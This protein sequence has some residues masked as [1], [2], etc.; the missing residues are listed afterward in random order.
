MYGCQWESNARYD[1]DDDDDPLR[2][3]IA[4]DDVEAAIW[5]DESFLPDADSF[6]EPATAFVAS[7]SEQTCGIACLAPPQAALSARMP[8]ATKPSAA[9][10]TNV[11]VKAPGESRRGGLWLGLSL[12]VA[13]FCLFQ[14]LPRWSPTDGLPSARNRQSVASASFDTNVSADYRVGGDSYIAPFI[15]SNSRS[16]P[17]L[18]SYTPS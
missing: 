10:K 17:S 2:E 9:R 11:K 13:F 7:N 1:F 5:S 15:P 14:A 4:M 8:R 16:F 12:V 18:A 6:D 3:A